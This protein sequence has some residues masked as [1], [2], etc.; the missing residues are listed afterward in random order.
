MYRIALKRY[1]SAYRT[2]STIKL[3][4]A[5]AL[6]GI[7][8]E[9]NINISPDLGTLLLVLQVNIWLVQTMLSTLL[10]CV[11]YLLV[12]CCRNI[13]IGEFAITCYLHACRHQNES[14]SRKY[15]AKVIWMLTYDDEKCTLAEAVDKYTI[16]VP[17]IQWLPWCVCLS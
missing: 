13:K 12:S 4:D 9:T 3:C 10:I 14:K 7:F 16:G 6:F 8:L 2:M 15:L 17:P 1:A 5:I 11:V